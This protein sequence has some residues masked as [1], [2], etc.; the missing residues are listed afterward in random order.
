[1]K[2]L[3]IQNYN[4]LFWTFVEKYDTQNSNIL[5]KIIHS[6]SVAEKCFSIASTLKLN[7][8]QREFAYL[9]GLFHDIGRFEQWRLHQTYN[10]KISV[11]HG[12][13]GEQMLLQNKICF[14]LSDEEMNVFVLAIKYHTKQYDGDDASV[15]LYNEIVKSADAFA[16]VITTANGAQQMTVDAD[17]YTDEILQDFL[18]LKP[19]WIYSPKTKL[20]K[21]LMLSAC[22]YYV[23]YD[24]LRK[25]ILQK[26]YIDIMF[27]TF[28]QYL[29]DIDK[30][31]YQNAINILKEKY[32]Q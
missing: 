30:A 7:K 3:T 2:D 26:N 25:E 32:I 23:K 11:D 8:K 12:D 4:Q 24:F 21:A 9:V 13:L 14:D 10:D 28:S 16:N 18:Q 15:V 19:L 6:Y 31:V 1:M 29:N 22:A 27:E 5:R 17:G 20:D